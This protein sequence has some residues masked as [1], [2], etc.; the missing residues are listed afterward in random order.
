MNLWP[1]TNVMV[2][3]DQYGVVVQTTYLDCVRS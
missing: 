2:G 1:T 3:V